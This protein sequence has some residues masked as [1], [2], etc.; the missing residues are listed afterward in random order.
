MDFPEK[1]KTTIST[2][3]VSK[4]T[5]ICLIMKKMIHPTEAQV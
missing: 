3:Q 4:G 1:E 2:I 5:E